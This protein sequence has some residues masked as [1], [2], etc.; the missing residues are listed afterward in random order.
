MLE[1]LGFF[2]WGKEGGGEHLG[3]IH[4]PFNP[5]RRKLPDE[6]EHPARAQADAIHSESAHRRR[7]AAGAEREGN[8][9]QPQHAF[10]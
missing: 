6:G 9:R 10:P 8:G 3:G 2:F 4:R 7:T 1:G 5:Q